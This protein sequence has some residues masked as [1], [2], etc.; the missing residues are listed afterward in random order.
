[1]TVI[2]AFIA[3]DL[4]A[5]LQTALDRTTVELRKTLRDMPLRWVR[6]ENIHL[7]LKFLGQVQAADIE[8]IKPVLER[9]AAAFAPM[10]VSIDGFGTFPNP[11]K[12][13]VL[14]IGLR[15][16]EGLA[17][18]QTAVEAD[19]S[20]LGFAPEERGFTPHL[21]VARVRRDHR[22]G[23]L[24]RIAELMAATQPP[25]TAAAKL[26]SVTL[27]RSDLKPGGSVYNPLVR[28]SLSGAADAT[29]DNKGE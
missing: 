29:A 9:Q 13:L 25:F 1:M 27:Y 2:R 12:P 23:N 6:T 14:W 18:F 3:I 20:Q 16:G 22:V 11:T 4:P 10:D 24:K 19:L 26:D 28:Y 8:R 5:P 21:T 7:T 15:A 17:K